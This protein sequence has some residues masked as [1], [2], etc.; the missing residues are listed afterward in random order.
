[1]FKSYISVLTLSMKKNK[2]IF[3]ILSLSPSWSPCPQLQ[4]IPTKFRSLWC[5]QGFSAPV[6]VQLLLM[7]RSTSS[8][9]L[10]KCIWMNNMKLLSDSASPN[11][12]HSIVH[13][14]GSLSTFWDSALWCVWAW[15]AE[16]LMVNPVR[17]MVQS[18]GRRVKDQAAGRAMHQEAASCAARSQLS[19]DRGVSSFAISRDCSYARAGRSYVGKETLL[20]R[21]TY[22][23][24]HVL[25]APDLHL[26]NS[27][28]GRATT[29]TY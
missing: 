1:M 3:I 25:L 13:R 9:L 28:A 16:G 14:K 29:A 18:L 24:D 15:K 23:M 7:K 8:K 5:N 19:S 11:W 21:T 2:C 26:A 4:C 17:A 6:L 12:L 27:V 10:A 20:F 22:C